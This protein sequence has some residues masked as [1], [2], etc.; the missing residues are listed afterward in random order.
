MPIYEYKCT[1]CGSEHEFIQRFSDKPKSKCPDCGG[2]LRKLISNTSFVLKGT[3][4]YVTDYASDDRKTKMEA[5]KPPEKK[6]PKKSDKKKSSKKESSKKLATE[7]A[8]SGAEKKASAA[9]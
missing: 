5:E 1:G 8:S 9:Q 3:G 6:T 7:K 2:K 4:W